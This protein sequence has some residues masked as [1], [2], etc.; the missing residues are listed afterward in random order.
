MAVETAKMASEQDTQNEKSTNETEQ[1]R[2]LNPP[3]SGT[4]QTDFPPE[5]K[6][7]GDN[8][9]Y[10]VRRPDRCR[11]ESKLTL[12]KRIFKFAGTLEYTLQAIAILA[13]IASG[14]GIALQTLIFG[15][16]ITA[17]I[18]FVS[19]KSDADAFMDDASGFA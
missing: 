14:A 13:A 19:G 10:L 2:S 5:D 6:E 15:K 8:G 7:D 18:D 17:I 4:D 12:A 3:L 16:V 1:S 9:G 11:R